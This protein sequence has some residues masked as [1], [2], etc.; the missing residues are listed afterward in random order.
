[1][2]KKQEI[3]QA[4]NQNIT[5]EDTETWKL[6]DKYHCK[7]GKEILDDLGSK[8][9]RISDWIID[10]VDRP[11]FQIGEYSWPVKLSRVKVEALGY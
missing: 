4:M 10:I 6:I 1:M 8:G 9:Y 5:L 2:N 3:K 11:S 7:T